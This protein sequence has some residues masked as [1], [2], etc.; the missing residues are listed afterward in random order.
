MEIP[1]GKPVPC[2]FDDF[3]FNIFSQS[4]FQWFSNHCVCAKHLSEDVSTTV[5][6]ND[7]TGS[8]TLISISENTL[9]ISCITQSMKSSP[10][11]K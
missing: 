6:Q 2:N 4:F 9:R 11:P 5:S 8:A 10:V 1:K 3:I 7:T